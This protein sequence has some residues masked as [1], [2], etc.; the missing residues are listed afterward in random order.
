MRPVR[1]DDDR[2]GQLVP[3]GQG[4]RLPSTRAATASVSTASPPRAHCRVGRSVD[5]HDVALGDE[6]V[7]LHVVDVP[8][9]AAFRGVQHHEHVVGVDVHLGDGGALHAVLHRLRV[10]PEDVGEHRHGVG[11]AG[12]QVDP[13]DAGVL[14]QQ[15]RQLVDGRPGDA[16]IGDPPDLHRST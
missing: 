5:R 15:S 4:S 3:G 16:V 11:V 13:E 9:V 8:A 12:G 1:A 7:E 6:L 14:L 10:E 2:R